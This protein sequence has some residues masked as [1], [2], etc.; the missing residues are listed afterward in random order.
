MVTKDTVDE[1]I[2]KMQERKAKMNAAILESGSG[3]T[4]QE[5]KQEEEAAK[6]SIIQSAVNRFVASPFVSNASRSAQQEDD[7]EEDG[8]DI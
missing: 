5:T 2:Y 1:D 3:S 6:Q 4:D 7:E 8:E